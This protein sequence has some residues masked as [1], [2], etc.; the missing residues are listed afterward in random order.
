RS[1]ACPRRAPSRQT[2]AAAAAS[3]APPASSGPLQGADRVAAILLAMG[4]SVA[5]KLMKHFNPDEIRAITRSV[6]DLPPVPAQQLRGLIEDF[7]IQ[8]ATGANLVGNA[9]E[10]QRLLAGVLPQEQIDEIMGDIMGNADRSIWDRISQVNETTLG[11][12]IGKEHPQVAALI[13]SK[14]NSGTAAKVIGH[15][16][17]ER[18]DSIFRRMLTLKPIVDETL[19]MIERTLHQEFTMSFAE[20][21]DGDPQSRIAEIINKLDREQ[22]EQVL[23]SLAASRPKAAEALKSKMFTFED[24]GKLSPKARTTLFGKVPGD[25]VMLA[26]KGA[27]PELKEIVLQSLSS[28]VRKM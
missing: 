13:L 7:A 28:R 5:G 21:S 3:N 4:K 22:M 9:T 1:Q 17:P 16:P 11:A 26:L 27:T 6:A 20:K 10:V 25:R 8:F 12:Y 15:L 14:V 18:R 19:R 23:Q 24:V 2:M